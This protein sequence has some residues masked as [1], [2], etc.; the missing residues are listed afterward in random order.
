MYEEA[1]KNYCEHGNLIVTKNYKTESG[2]SLGLWL[3]TQRQVYKGKADGVLTD[4]QIARLNAIGIVWDNYHDL[5]WEKS[6][7]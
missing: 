5:S 2:L 1:K 4:E 3:N 7:L 6:Y